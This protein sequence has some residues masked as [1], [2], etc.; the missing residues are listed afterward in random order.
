LKGDKMSIISGYCKQCG[1]P[2]SA[3]CTQ[4]GMKLC[5][6][7]I[8][9]HKCETESPP[10][11]ELSNSAGQSETVKAAVRKPYGPRVKK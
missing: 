3:R 2:A 1:F 9:A 5:G 8:A 7:C 11:L 10:E 6:N 4:C